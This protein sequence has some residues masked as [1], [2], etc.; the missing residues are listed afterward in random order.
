MDA[1]FRRMHFFFVSII[2]LVL[3][4]GAI[5]LAPYAQDYLTTQAQEGCDAGSIDTGSCLVAEAAGLVTPP[6]A[7]SAEQE[8]AP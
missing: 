3:V 7:D 4:A 2:I 1:T 5:V 8:V 6:A